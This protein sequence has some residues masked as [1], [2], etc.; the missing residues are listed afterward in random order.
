MPV[1]LG[2]KTVDVELP[3]RVEEHLEKFGEYNLRDP[4]REL[5]DALEVKTAE[6][7][8]KEKETFFFLDSSTATVSV[9]SNERAGVGAMLRHPEAEIK[10]VFLIQSSGETYI[11]ALTAEI[12]LGCLKVKRNPRKSGNLGPVFST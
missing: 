8:K 4:P 10:E 11:A 9:N 5:L 2:L 12:P 3:S 6:W 7:D 1:T